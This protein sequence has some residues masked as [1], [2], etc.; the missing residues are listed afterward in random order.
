MQTVHASDE[1][2]GEYSY[3]IKEDGT[4]KLESYEGEQED[5]IIPEYIEGMR[6]SELDGT[7][8]NSDVTTV[9]IPKT[10]E[11]ITPGSL[12][13]FYMQRIDVDAD[14]PNYCSIDGVLFD[15][16]VKTLCQYPGDH[17]KDIYSIPEG[18][19]T[20]EMY[21]FDFSEQLTNIILPDSLKIVRDSAFRLVGIK[22]IEF[23]ENVEV[24]EPSCIVG[25]EKLEEIDV[26]PQNKFY[27]EID[28]VLF[29]KNIEVLLAYPGGKRNEEYDV[30]EGI[31]QIGEAAFFKCENLKK[32]TL[33]ETLEDIG[34]EAF[35]SCSGLMEIQI[36]YNVKKLPEEVFSGCTSLKN[37]YL[38]YGLEDIDD[39][40]LDC[41]SENLKEIV[42]PE[43]VVS[44]SDYAFSDD[45]EL[46]VRENSYAYTW[47]EEH[48]MKY[49]CIE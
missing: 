16:K 46:L 9:K 22:N 6:V 49:R 5:V 45:T 48:N 25:C 43:T 47:A 39:F 38:P 32:I 2:N 33:P 20:I 31:K 29:D 17:G 12:A 37:I 10:I 7:F 19:E 15:K 21:A 24:I 14:N 35:G 28:G 4:I 8:G 36:P 30:P 1:S 27:T 26:S 3:S 18:I 34:A 42:L 13:G 11:M 44:I 41:Y 40:A 23:S